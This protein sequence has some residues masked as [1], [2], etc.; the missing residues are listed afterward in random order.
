[1]SAGVV[2][3]TVNQLAPP[4]TVRARIPIVSPRLGELGIRRAQVLE[5]VAPM[6]SPTGA[7][8]EPVLFETTVAPLTPTATARVADAKAAPKI[9]WVDGLTELPWLPLSVVRTSCPPQLGDQAGARA[10]RS[11]SMRARAPRRRR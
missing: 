7:H 5:P 2:T 3:P 9:F 8:V 6:P 1:M 4:S 10:W 11:R